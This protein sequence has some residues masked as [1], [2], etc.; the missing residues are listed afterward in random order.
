MNSS[1]FDQVIQGSTRHF[2]EMPSC[3][4]EEWTAGSVHVNSRACETMLWILVGLKLAGLLMPQDLEVAIQIDNEV[5][6]VSSPSSP[7]PHH[8]SLLRLLI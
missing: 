6:W 8:K 5:C 3:F 1:S 7:F 4:V 2:L